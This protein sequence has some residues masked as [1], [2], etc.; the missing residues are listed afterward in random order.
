MVV[1]HKKTDGPPPPRTANSEQ[2]A[3]TK[4]P[5]DAKKRGAKIERTT[6]REEGDAESKYWGRIFKGE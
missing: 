1:K 2:C 3:N 6:G 5:E 4:V